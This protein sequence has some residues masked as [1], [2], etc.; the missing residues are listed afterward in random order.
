[1]LRLGLRAKFFL[2]SNTVIAVTMTLATVLAVIHERRARFDEIERQAF[3]LAQA[4][5]IPITDA[6]MYEDLGLVVE[7]G[8]TENYVNAVL[9]RNREL[10][11]Y[12]IVTDRDGI[13]THSSRWQLLASRFARA[14]DDCGS[15]AEPVVEL[16]DGSGREQLLEVRAPLRISS[17]CWGTLA[18]GFTLAP[19]E[20]RV[21]ELAVQ[22]GVVAV[23]LMLGNS[24]LTAVYVESLIRP[25]LE[26]NETMKSASTGNLDVR[27]RVRR[28]DEVGELAAAFNRMMDE[29]QQLRELEQ[30]RQAQLAHTEKM[31]AVGALASGVAH[32]VNNPLG[33]I[34]TCI[35][36]IQQ[37]PDDAE[38]RA[39]YLDLIRD[40]LKR[41][42]RT[43]SNLLGFA[44]PRA[45]RLEPT[46]INHSLRHVMELVRYQMVKQGIEA[47]WRLDPSEPQVLA[48]HYQMEQLFLNLV[49]NAIAAMPD[50][51]RLTLVSM[52]RGTDVVAEVR[53][54]GTGIPPGILDRIFDPFFTTREVGEGTGLGLA[55]SDMIVSAHG[56]RI[57]VDSEPG[58]GSTFRVVLP[59]LSGPDHGGES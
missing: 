9:E 26:L 16:L 37:N 42:E 32:E 21:R 59:G 28:S 45:M 17:R 51:G 2:Y 43:V 56:G 40:G 5:A 36:N 31:A 30:A 33:G 19:I 24:L 38:M 13:V 52:R 50:G 35:E 18:V 11:R 47:E 39:R 1:M 23:L 22:A 53:D 57:E 34:L 15:V 54:T 10:L 55:V 44:R 58:R 3:T 8:L 12:V 41:I 46:P 29:L 49:L 6:L 48:D 7:T 27:S 14:L 4:M 25:I 20:A